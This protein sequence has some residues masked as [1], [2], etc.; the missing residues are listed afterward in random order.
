[1]NL[2]DASYN[3]DRSQLFFNYIANERVDF[4]ELAK[5]LASLYKVRIELRQVGPRDKAKEVGGLGPC[6]RA[7][8]C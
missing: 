4:R 3:F 6:G 2:L 7:L 5:Q 8:C 1:M